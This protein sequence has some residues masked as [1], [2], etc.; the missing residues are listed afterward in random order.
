MP[1]DVAPN[2]HGTPAEG[3]QRP[4]D[5][6]AGQ[7]HHLKGIHGHN[8]PPGS[9][10][11]PTSGVRMQPCIA[12]RQELASMGSMAAEMLARHRSLLCSSP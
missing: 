12:L 3:L 1:C 4:E 11:N 10:Q 9:L 2:L 8:I 5:L 7:A 6:Q